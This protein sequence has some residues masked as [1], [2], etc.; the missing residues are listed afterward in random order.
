[1]T[2]KIQNCQTTAR[3]RGWCRKHYARWYKNGDPLISLLDRET[4]FCTLSACNKPIEAK[5]LCKRHYLAELTK[6]PY[7]VTWRGMMSRCYQHSH[8]SYMDY[9]GRGIMVCDRWK[10][11]E[12]YRDDIFALGQRPTSGHT[13][14]RINNNDDYRPGNIRWATGLEQNLNR[15]IF[16][17]NKLGIKGVSLYR[18]SKYVAHIRINGKKTHLGYFSTV[19]AAAKAYNDAARRQGVLHDTDDQ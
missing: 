18:K 2:C 5:G 15:R 6:Q 10:T 12:N 1:M 4:K 11:Y 7:Y 13:L 14:D 19:E 16:R 17:N 8:R 3:A 9:G